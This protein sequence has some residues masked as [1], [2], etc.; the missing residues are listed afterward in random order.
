MYQQ[1]LQG[2]EKVWGPEHTSTLDNNLG[3]ARSVMWASGSSLPGDRS[4]T[5]LHNH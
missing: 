3:R 2:K 5:N 4:G 1:A